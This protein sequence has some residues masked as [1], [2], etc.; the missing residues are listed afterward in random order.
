MYRH[1][2]GTTPTVTDVTHEPEEGY[3]VEVVGWGRARGV[4][5][6]G[7]GDGGERGNE[8]NVA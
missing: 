4:E 6:C 8:W 2:A 7:G 1:D 3:E 5:G